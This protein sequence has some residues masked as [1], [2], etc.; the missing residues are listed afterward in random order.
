MKPHYVFLLAMMLVAG[1][2]GVYSM[3]GIPT[4]VFPAAVVLVGLLGVCFGYFAA[5]SRK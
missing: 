2:F 5:G 1:L 4:W 3:I